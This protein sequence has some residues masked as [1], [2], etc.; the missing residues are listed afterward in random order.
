MAS[1][2]DDQVISFDC[3]NCGQKISK[4][5]RE[6]KRQPDFKCPVCGLVFDATDF[7]A[8]IEDAEKALDDFVDGI[9]DINISI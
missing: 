5:V 6:I 3:T 4:S 1:P 7:T 2:F 9:G 8:G